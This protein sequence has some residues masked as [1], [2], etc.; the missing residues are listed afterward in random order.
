M[1]VKSAF[2]NGELQEEV[3]VLQPQGFVV[4]G[5]EHKVLRL[6]K[7]HTRFYEQNRMHNYMYD[8]IKFHTY[9]DVIIK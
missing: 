1:D 6:T 2:L 9:S 4:E 8:R 3:Y 5:Q 7:C